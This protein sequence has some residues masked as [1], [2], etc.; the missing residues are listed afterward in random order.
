MM[1]KKVLGRVIMEAEKLYDSKR[2]IFLDS[3]P[4]GKELDVHFSDWGE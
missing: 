4:P 1:L 2:D 3:F